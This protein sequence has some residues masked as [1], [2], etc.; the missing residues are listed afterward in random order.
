MV[1][2]I[3]MKMKM[4]ISIEVGPVVTCMIVTVNQLKKSVVK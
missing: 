1:C 3:V 4:D 2:V